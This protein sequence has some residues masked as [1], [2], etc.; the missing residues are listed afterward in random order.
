MAV[1]SSGIRSSVFGSASERLL[2]KA[3][4]TRWSEQLNIYPN[5][6]FSNIIHAGESQFAGNEIRFLRA[7]SLDFTLCDTSDRPILSIEFDGLGEGF[8][9]DGV[10]VPRYVWKKDP[11][12]EWKINFKLRVCESVLYPLFVVSFEETRQLGPDVSLS[13]IDGI[14]GQFLGGLHTQERVNELA[15][16]QRD[17]IDGWPRDDLSLDEFLSDLVIEAEVEM[18]MAW[19]PIYRRRSELMNDLSGCDPGLKFSMR[20]IDPQAEVTSLS[21]PLV[22][23]ERMQSFTSAERSGAEVTIQTSR[24][25]VTETIWVRNVGDWAMG[26]ALAD[27]IAQLLAF[28]RAVG[29]FREHQ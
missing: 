29:L 11:N 20:R 3:L 10:Y 13:V 12:R 1:A 27:Q 26:D 28:K 16:E 17:I 19:N 5:L 25:D 15:E 21:T 6:P 22:A 8:S 18:Q 7:T 4:K 14:I 23:G 2:Y 9:R 24:G